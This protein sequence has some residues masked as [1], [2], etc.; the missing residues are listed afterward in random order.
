MGAIE[1][2]DKGGSGNYLLPAR[3]IMN[4]PGGLNGS[5]CIGLLLGN[6]LPCEKAS[7]QCLNNDDALASVANSA[8]KEDKVT[9]LADGDASVPITDVASTI[10]PTELAVAM[11]SSLEY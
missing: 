1:V 5:C 4:P 10:A 7:D 11:G 3:S 8:V 6:R 9:I 2:L